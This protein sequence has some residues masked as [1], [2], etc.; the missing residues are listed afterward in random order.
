[1]GTE[2]GHKGLHNVRAK[3]AAESNRGRLQCFPQ[4]WLTAAHSLWMKWLTG[5]VL[6]PQRCNYPQGYFPAI[7]WLF[8]P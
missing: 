8:I 4:L 1:M 5:P 2:S 7:F 6:E 3:R